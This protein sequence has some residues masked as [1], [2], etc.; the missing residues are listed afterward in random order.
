MRQS[1]TV[2]VEQGLVFV[3]YDF[4]GIY[5]TSIGTFMVLWRQ[6][7]LLYC[8]WLYASD[9]VFIWKF[10]AICIEEWLNMPN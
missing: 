7:E 5:S 2:E 1:V 9:E 3:F 4:D 10:I 6:P 8:R